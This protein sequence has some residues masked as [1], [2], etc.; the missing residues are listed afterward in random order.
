[1]SACHTI[2]L[3]RL[4]APDFNDI[5]VVSLSRNVSASAHDQPN[6]K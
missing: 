3:D 5:R 4:D 2:W 6:R 1:M